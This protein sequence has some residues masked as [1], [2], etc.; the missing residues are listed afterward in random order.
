MITRSKTTG[1]LPGLFLKGMKERKGLASRNGREGMS[2]FEERKVYTLTFNITKY[3]VNL[4]L[5]LRGL[6]VRDKGHHSSCC[7][8]WHWLLLL[9]VS[10]DRQCYPQRLYFEPD[11]IELP[12]DAQARSDSSTSP[13]NWGNIFKHK[14]RRISGQ[15]GRNLWRRATSNRREQVG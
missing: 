8:V 14:Y 5:S 1:A 10:S 7:W 12:V 6:R 9:W 2:C 13:C 15:C 11:W 4:F 3:C